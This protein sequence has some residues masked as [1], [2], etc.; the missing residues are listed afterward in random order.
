[1]GDQHTVE[2][3]TVSAS[4]T[5]ETLVDDQEKKTTQQSEIHPTAD[6]QKSPVDEQSIDT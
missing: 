5:Q 1:M 4:V 3:A 6:I 2:S